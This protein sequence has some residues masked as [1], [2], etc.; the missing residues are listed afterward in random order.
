MGAG[1][2]TVSARTERELDKEVRRVVEEIRRRYPGMD[3]A[4]S[5]V[6][7]E[8]DTEMW[9]QSVRFDSHGVRYET[10]EV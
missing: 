10:E 6:Y 3:V 8:P 5:G 7:Y 4:T 1:T 2:K 9:Y